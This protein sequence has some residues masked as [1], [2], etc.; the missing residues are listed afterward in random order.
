MHGTSSSANTTPL[1]LRSTR[2]Y[3]GSP[4]GQWEIET[5]LLFETLFGG[6]SSVALAKEGAGDE[7]RT[8]DIN[9]GK[10]ALYH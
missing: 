1:K 7:I 6:L 5:A 9:L 2:G 10:V 4:S 8:R 3:G